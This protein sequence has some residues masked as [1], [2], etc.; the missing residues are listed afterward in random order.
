MRTN[1]RRV[2][3]GDGLSADCFDELVVDEQALWL[4][5]CYSV[6]GCEISEEAGHVGFIFWSANKV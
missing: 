3:R 6:R 2:N 4:A 1:I 5:P